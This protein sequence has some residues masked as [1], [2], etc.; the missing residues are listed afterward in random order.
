MTLP[1]IPIGVGFPLYKG[2]E[3]INDAIETADKAQQDS[4]SAME[5]SESAVNTASAAET[6]ADS[7]QEQFNQVVIEGDS[8]VEAAQARVDAEGNSF[9]TLK[10]RLDNGDVLLS[11]ITYNVNSFPGATDDEKIVNAF[12][13]MNGLSGEGNTLFFPSRFARYSLTS[14]V[15]ANGKWNLKMET[16]ISYQGTGIAVTIQNAVR[17]SFE[18]MVVKGVN[19][20]G[21]F[22]DIDQTSVGIK[23][24][25]INWCEIK[26]RDIKGFYHN[27][28]FDNSDNK[29]SC[30]NNISLGLIYDGFI[31]IY[32]KQRF[33][34]GET[35]TWNN[36]NTFYGGQV[37]KSG[38]YTPAKANTVNVLNEGNNNTFINTALE[39]A[40]SQYSF[41]TTS[42]G[43]SYINC[44]YEA[45]LDNS[46][47]FEGSN[48]LSNLVLGGYGLGSEIIS[49][50]SKQNATISNNRGFQNLTTFTTDGAPALSAFTQTSSADALMEFGHLN[51]IIT[52]L[53][54]DGTLSLFHDTTG[55]YPQLEFKGRYGTVRF[56][57]GSSATK[58]GVSVD[59]NPAA[60]MINFEN[61]NFEFKNTASLSY[62]VSTI[63]DGTTAINIAKGQVFKTTNSAAT[64]INIHT[65]G[66]EG[67]PVYIVAGDSNTT[68]VH[69]SMIKLKGSISR[70]LTN[71]E[72]VHF[73]RINGTLVEV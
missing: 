61:F 49:L 11:D 33:L 19:Y 44:R 18:I 71:G 17:R 7:V 63:P 48:C 32:L 28:L 13:F 58:S 6:K 41:K 15:V 2:V 42:S 23:F 40:S 69:G 51:R 30:Y 25:N 43:N 67:K 55:D 50:E 31:D 45:N 9:T 47:R 52:K 65:G 56:G 37:K 38:S 36:Q 62:Q 35:L 22:T 26:L 57:H 27:V 24:D 8:S 39:G 53:L 72:V 59:T 64:S 34:N 29:G 12:N 46:L 14:S 20:A 66:R 10:D 3:Y 70:L 54:G 5:T 16:A 1:K 21:W 4:A 73:L 68:L 60:D